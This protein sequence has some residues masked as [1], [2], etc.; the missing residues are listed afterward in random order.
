MQPPAMCFEVKRLPKIKI[1]LVLSCLAATGIVTISQISNSF[2]F[3]STQINFPQEKSQSI[4]GCRT[5]A[6]E[7][8]NAAAGSREDR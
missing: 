3:A 5:E 2:L 8:A 6:L 1:F 4:K 7:K